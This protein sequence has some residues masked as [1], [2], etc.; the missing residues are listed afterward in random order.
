MMK[1]MAEWIVLW[2]VALPLPS[3]ACTC[4]WTGPLLRVAPAS[5]LIVRGKVLAHFDRSRGVNRAMDVEVYEV[6]KGSLK[7]RRVRIWG[8]DGAQCRP[9]VAGFPVGTEWIFAVSRRRGEPDYA[10]SVCGE[11]WAHVEGELVIGRLAS[12][13][14]PGVDD[15]LERMTLRDLRGKLRQR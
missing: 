10:I 7:G 1:S 2:A 3:L 11:Y 15:T 13:K 4:S 14:P 5:D 12:T 6:L 9:Y 8:D